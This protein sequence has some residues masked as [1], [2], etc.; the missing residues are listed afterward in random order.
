MQVCEKSSD[1][2]I[3]AYKYEIE[4]KRTCTCQ[5]QKPGHTHLIHKSERAHTTYTYGMKLVERKGYD[6]GLNEIQR[7]RTA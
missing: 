3:K 5:T 6:C 1:T 2:I 7:S 4:L